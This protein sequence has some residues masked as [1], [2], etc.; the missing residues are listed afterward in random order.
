MKRLIFS[1]LPGRDGCNGT[2]VRSD[3]KKHIISLDFFIFK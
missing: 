3:K 2:K 1:G